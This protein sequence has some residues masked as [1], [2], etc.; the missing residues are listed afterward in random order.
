M[1]VSTELITNIDKILNTTFN[2]YKRKETITKNLIENYYDLIISNIEKNNKNNNINLNNINNIS[3]KNKLKNIDV[4]I[5]DN[6]IKYNSS[7]ISNDYEDN[8]AD[9]IEN[10]MDI[11]PDYEIPKTK[12]IND[13]INIDDNIRCNANEW[14][15]L[16]CYNRCIREVDKVNGTY[17]KIHLEYRPYGVI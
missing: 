6:N 11:I 5:N 1:S 2:K 10:P 17:C 16:N 9:Y 3:K 13:I 8:C 4:N 15:P 14:A 12:K 7:K